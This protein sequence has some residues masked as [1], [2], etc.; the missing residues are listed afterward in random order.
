MTA[1]S[2]DGIVIGGGVSGLAAACYLAKAKKRVLVVEA[3]NALGGLC[4]SM[5]LGEGFTAPAGAHALYALDPR[6]VKELKLAKHGLKF[7]VRDMALVGLGGKPLVLTRDAS[8][9]ARHIAAHSAADAEAWPRFREELFSMARALRPLWWEARPSRPLHEAA[10]ETLERLKRLSAAAWLESWFESDALKAALAFDAGPAPFEPGSALLLVWRAAQE[11]CGLQG[12]VAWPLGGPAA[13]IAALAAA[14]K[15][16][17]V[18]IQ[19]GTHAARILLQDG[20]AVGVE[21]ASGEAV[22]APLV[23]SSL[24]RRR[25]LCELAPGG[26]AG[27][28]ALSALPTPAPLGE[29]KVLIALKSLPPMGSAPDTS[30]FVVAD[31]LDAYAAATSAARAGRLPDE[32]VFEFVM[33]SFAE[34]AL[35]PLGQHVLSARVRPVPIAMDD[36][37]KTALG[38]KV[39][40][41]LEAHRNGISKHIAAIT[42]LSPKDIETRYG[43]NEDTDMLADWNARIMTPIPGLLLCGAEPVPAASGRA[44]RI[45]A[46]LASGTPR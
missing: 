22:A 37:M 4:E 31:R 28:D 2:F 39:V 21:L 18:E 36:V 3:R 24:S 9:T 26:A 41:T 13:L 46:T 15:K 11:M 16:L 32:L 25:T 19:T 17:G 45:A 33:P 30:R 5:P 42:V 1:R 10:V 40:S 29:A 20:A 8:D 43:Y 34:P 38:A 27:F 7:A 35:A 23:L 44:G 12:A 6:L 14:A